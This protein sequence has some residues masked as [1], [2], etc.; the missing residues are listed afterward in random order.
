MNESRKTCVN[1]DARN[2][3]WAPLRPRARIHSFNAKRDLLISAPSIPV[4][5]S[6]KK[7]WFFFHINDGDQ[8][9]NEKS[10][11]RVW[12]FADEVSA[13]RSLPAKSTRENFPWR[14]VG[15]ARGRRMTWN[16]ACE[17]DCRENKVLKRWRVSYFWNRRSGLLPS[18]RWRMLTQ[19]FALHCHAELIWAPLRHY[20]RSV[21]R[22]PPTALVVYRLLGHE[23]WLYH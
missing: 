23:V 11:S 1:F 12:R 8:T 17:R 18:E 10:N 13:P 7:V 19:M 3:K 9:K 15:L 6:V 2:G 4:E 22:D 14:R 5:I 20:R 16:T 21:R